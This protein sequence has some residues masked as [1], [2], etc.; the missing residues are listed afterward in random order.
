MPPCFKLPMLW[1]L[2]SLD[3]PSLLR[4]KPPL[5]GSEARYGQHHKNDARH[6]QA[7]DK[8]AVPL[9]LV[10]VVRQPPYFKN[11]QL[12][13]CAQRG[14]QVAALGHIPEDSFLIYWF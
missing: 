6:L 11:G 13:T 9:R 10:H 5:E 8:N 4:C 12:S 7:E 1:L 2:R 14:T 3:C